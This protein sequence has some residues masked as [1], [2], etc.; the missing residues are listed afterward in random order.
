MGQSSFPLTFT[1]VG[2]QHVRVPGTRKSRSLNERFGDILWFADWGPSADGTADVTS[3]LSDAIESAAAQH[4]S[5]RIGAGQYLL[6]SMHLSFSDLHD[7]SIIFDQGAELLDFGQMVTGIG[8]VNTSPFPIPF[9]IEFIGC[10]GIRWHGGLVRTIFAKGGSSQ[11]AFGPENYTLRKPALSFYE[12][13]DVILDGVGRAGSP[14]RGISGP[15]RDQ[16]I[17]YYGLVIGVDGFTVDDYQ[18][19]A[20]RSS[21]INFFKPI[22]CHY[23]NGWHVPGSGDGKEQITW[24]APRK[25]SWGWQRHLNDGEAQDM[26]SLGKITNAEVMH[27]HDFLVQDPSNSSLVDITGTDITFENIYADI[28]NGKIVDVSHEQGLGCVPSSRVLLRNLRSTGRAPVCAVVGT[29]EATVLATPITDVTM[30]D[31]RCNIDRSD[32]TGIIRGVSMTTVKSFKIVREI[33]RNVSPSG[34]SL[35]WG[36]GE[37]FQFIDSEY[38]WEQASSALDPSNRVVT[39][40]VKNEYRGCRFRAN[41]SLSGS[42]L[43]LETLAFTTNANGSHEFFNCVFIDTNIS[44]AQGANVRFTGCELVSFTWQID[45]GTIEFI[46]CTL[47]GVPMDNLCKE[48][49][50]VLATYSTPAFRRAALNLDTFIRELIEMDAWGSIARLVLAVTDAEDQALCD[51]RNP[52]SSNISAAGGVTWTENQGIHG[53]GI[54]GHV[55]LDLDVTTSDIVTQDSAYVGVWAAGDG[56]VYD[57]GSSFLV[58]GSSTTNILINTRSASDGTLYRVNDNS[59]LVVANTDSRGY[60]SMWR[61]GS[62]ARA[63]G[64]NGVQV[65]ADSQASATPNTTSLCMSRRNAV[66]C[67]Q[68]WFATIVGS[69]A[70]A[71]LDAR[72]YES[73]RRLLRSR[74]AVG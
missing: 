23:L 62:S 58:G 1:S 19:F 35:I 64:K 46:G 38:T 74:G 57:G 28:P 45:S 29:S 68:P 61:T 5:L 2:G 41:S 4:K 31:V 60:F 30:E 51:I 37:L 55:I 10:T 9:G 13:E 72:I 70:L 66:Y 49:R 32:F 63:A 43:G 22:N 6:S 27:V 7:F 18:Y 26:A 12:C 21:F 34:A 52:E 40:S 44:I 3:L 54:D 67:S 17:L 59:S 71:A 11:D 39:C 15:N 69:A 73:L 36:G 48:T 56:G 20:H 53:D 25:C 50:A 8:G 42:G 65:G 24:T 14:G 16:I 47:D 33:A